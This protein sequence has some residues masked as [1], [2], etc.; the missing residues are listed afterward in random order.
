VRWGLKRQRRGADAP[1]VIELNRLHGN[2]VFFV[3]ADLIETIEARPDTTITLVNKHR[4]VVQDAVSDVVERVIGFRARV[5]HAAGNDSDH[6]AGARA[7]AA[8]EDQ[9][10]EQAA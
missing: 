7:F 1:K 3:N 9:N 2:G 8:I 4:Y 5:A 10:E 6:V